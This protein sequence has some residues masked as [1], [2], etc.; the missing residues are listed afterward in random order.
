MKLSYGLVSMVSLKVSVSSQKH[1]KTETCFPMI[2]MKKWLV[3]E[4]GLEPNLVSLEQIR[5]KYL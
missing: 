4:T 1:M 2:S 5:S 3:S